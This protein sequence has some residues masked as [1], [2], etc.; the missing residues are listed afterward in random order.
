VFKFKYINTKMDFKNNSD[1]KK[2]VIAQ[3][4][5][6]DEP[7]FNFNEP[8]GIQ[9]SR[10]DLRAGGGLGAGEDPLSSNTEFLGQGNNLGTF[11][12]GIGGNILRPE[13]DEER[14]SLVNRPLPAVGLR[15]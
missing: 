7:A 13:E 1:S 4:E 14:A 9:Q 6:D 3:D 2:L 11:E 12:R 8:T 10:D 15:S 5:R